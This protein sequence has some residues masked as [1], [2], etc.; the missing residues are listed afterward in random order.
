MKVVVDTNIF[1]SG[2]LN[3]NGSPAK[4]INLIL[5]EK[6]QV[7]FDIRI[8]QEYELVLKRA[9]FGFVSDTV[10]PIIDFIR[11]EGLFVIAVPINK[12]FTDED[13]KKFYEIMKSGNSNYLIT[14]NR[15]HFP[16]EKNIVVPKDFLDII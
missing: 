4:I 14:G 6:I 2:L 3:P 12:K 1:V 7:L 15:R 5:N 10:D 9:K 13:D 11:K 16:K 8:I